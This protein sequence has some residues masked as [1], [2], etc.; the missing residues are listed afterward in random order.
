VASVL[1]LGLF[2]MLA[3]V[4]IGLVWLDRLLDAYNAFP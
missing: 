4:V 2:I 1:A 3:A